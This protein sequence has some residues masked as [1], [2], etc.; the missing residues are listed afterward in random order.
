MHR[1]YIDEKG[2]SCGTAAPSRRQVT[3][4]PLKANLQLARRCI[5]QSG[6]DHVVA[7]MSLLPPE[8]SISSLP[9]RWLHPLFPPHQL[10]TFQ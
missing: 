10:P 9:V 1:G 2:R 5:H 6:L 8:K 4:R 7:S 3:G